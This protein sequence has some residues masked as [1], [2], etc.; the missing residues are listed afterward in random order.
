MTYVDL[1]GAMLDWYERGFPSTQYRQAMTIVSLSFFGT[2]NGVTGICVL[3]AAERW[4]GIASR[5]FVPSLVYVSAAVVTT[6]HCV[7]ATTLADSLRSK[8][9]IRDSN[10]SKRVALSYM[11]ASSVICVVALWTSS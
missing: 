8:R 5:Q 9:Q 4:L 1:Y 3:L 11:I 2:L 10:H 6:L 7:F